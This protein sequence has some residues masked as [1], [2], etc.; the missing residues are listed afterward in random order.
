MNRWND[1]DYMFM[2]MVVCAAVFTFCM[3]K[4][5][6]LKFTKKSNTFRKKD[7]E[8]CREAREAYLTFCKAWKD[9][10]IFELSW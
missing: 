1:E 6:D 9:G 4:Y 8:H 5:F 2:V 10:M 3:L 7:I